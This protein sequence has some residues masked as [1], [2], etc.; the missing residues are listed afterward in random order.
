MQDN[1]NTNMADNARQIERKLS[2]ELRSLYHE[3]TKLI[4]NQIQISEINNERNTK[5]QQAMKELRR[6]NTAIRN[7]NE[8]LRKKIRK[9]ETGARRSQ[10][11]I[12]GH[13][14]KSKLKTDRMEQ[15]IRKI[16]QNLNEVMILLTNRDEE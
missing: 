1:L 2:R 4:F 16:K 7:I 5:L 13:K 3:M 10:L 8:D 6:K 12:T 11:D 15:E 14:I 9:M